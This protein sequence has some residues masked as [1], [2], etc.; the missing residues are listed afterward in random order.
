MLARLVLTCWPYVIH[1][2]QPPKVLGLEVWATMPGCELLL[3]M[4]KTTTKNTLQ[5]F[6]IHTSYPTSMDFWKLFFWR[7]N[8]FKHKMCNYFYIWNHWKSLLH[9]GFFFFLWQSFVLV[10]Q[11]G[12]QWCHLISPQP[13]TP[14]LKQSSCLS[15]PNSWDCR[16]A[17]P[18]PANLL[19][20]VEIGC[21]VFPRLV[22]NSWTP[23]VL[24]PRPLKELVPHLADF[25]LYHH[26]WLIFC[27][28]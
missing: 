2:P 25:L 12:V 6:F 22:L 10:A 3:K 28:M 9:W 14:G 16:H 4:T 7:E 18:Y 19:F 24:P 26:S 8:N 11:A 1:L 15:L 20:F 13:Q 27:L 23:A 21:T 17:S 5:S